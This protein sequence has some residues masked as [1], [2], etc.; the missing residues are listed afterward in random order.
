LAPA[1]AALQPPGRVGQMTVGNGH[2][3]VITSAT[4]ICAKTAGQ[5]AAPTRV[6]R[7]V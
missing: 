4:K 5:P 1:A 2:S 3:I 6:T 7:L